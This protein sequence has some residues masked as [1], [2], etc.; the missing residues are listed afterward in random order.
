MVAAL[1]VWVAISTIRERQRQ[2]HLATTRPTLNS[3][4]FVRRFV[5]AGVDERVSDFIWTEF[6]PYYF[7]P[8]TP[9]PEDRPISEMRIDGDDLSEMVTKFEKKFDRRWNGKWV[10]PDDPTLLDFAIALMNSTSEA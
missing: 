9:Y 8:L 3:S 10:G 6:Q 1:A 4:E 5:A 2:Q 7:A